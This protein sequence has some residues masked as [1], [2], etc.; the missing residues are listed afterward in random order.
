MQPIEKQVMDI[1]TMDSFMRLRD[2]L[3]LTDRQKEIFVLKYSRGL[4]NIDIAEELDPPITQ[5]TVGA[6]V[7][8]IRQKLAAIL[9]KNI[10][11]GID[12]V[13]IEWYNDA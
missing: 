3:N 5:D 9:R 12:S 6:D 2:S 10:E 1:P 4:R 8:I 11:M 13:T 7:K